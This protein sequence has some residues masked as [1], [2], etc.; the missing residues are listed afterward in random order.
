MIYGRPIQLAARGPTPARQSSQTG[1]PISSVKTRK[2]KITP[3]HKSF[4]PAER[5]CVM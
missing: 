5:F 2:K 1:P 4:K 3:Q